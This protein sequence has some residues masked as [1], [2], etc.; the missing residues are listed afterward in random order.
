MI[1]KEKEKRLYNLDY[2]LYLISFFF[3]NYEIDEY[4]YI[5]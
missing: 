5:F 3:D 1:K 2:C 4:I